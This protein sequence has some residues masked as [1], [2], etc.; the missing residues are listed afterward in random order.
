MIDKK[1]TSQIK[2]EKNIF[3]KNVI[4]VYPVIRW[5]AFSTLKSLKN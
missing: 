1:K 2:K 5:T 4:I 3:K